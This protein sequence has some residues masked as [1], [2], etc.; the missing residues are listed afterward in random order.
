MKGNGPCLQLFYCYTQGHQ[1]VKS[2]GML[3]EMSY[4]HNASPRG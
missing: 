3:D 4:L 1:P 2:K